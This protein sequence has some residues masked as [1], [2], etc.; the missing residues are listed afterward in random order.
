MAEIWDLY[1]H[2][3]EL[4]GR[5]VE[6]GAPIPAGCRHLVVG[7]WVV[8]PE[9]GVL[10]TLRHPQK[11]HYPGKWENSGGAALTGESAEAAAMRELFEE[12]GISVKTGE[13]EY[14]RTDKAGKSFIAT[15]LL[16]RKINLGSL[17]M[18]D[19]ETVGAKLACLA[20]ID[21]MAGDG[22]LAAP[23]V[24]RFY[25]VRPLLEKALQADAL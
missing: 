25:T 10:L 8:S 9:E 24:K 7:I 2:S 13:L 14:I 11:E 5:T 16:R 21:T 23:L 15:F 19:G 18:Q 12:T 1:S 4:L 22:A 3:G 6:R 20:E 17:V